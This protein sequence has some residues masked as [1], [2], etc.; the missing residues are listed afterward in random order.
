MVYHVQ[1]ESHI[2]GRKLP[3]QPIEPPSDLSSQLGA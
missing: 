1:G 3:N 2:S